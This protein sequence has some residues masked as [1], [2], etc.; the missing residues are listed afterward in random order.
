MLS[1]LLPYKR[2]DLALEAARRVG[3]PAVVAGDGPDRQAG[4]RRSPDPTRSS[5]AASTTTRSPACIAGASAFFLGGEEDF[6]ITPLEANAAGRPVVAYGG[7][8]ALETVRDGD[9][10]VLFG[11][12][13]PEEAAAG[14]ERALGTTW[15]PD[16]LATHA[17][18]YSAGT[19]LDRLER[20]VDE[21]L[22]AAGGMSAPEASIVIVTRNA[23]A[24]CVKL[25]RSLPR[26][27]DV[28]YEVVVVDNRSRLPTR[29]LLIGLALTGRIN[30]LC[31]MDRN[32]LF[33]EGNN[34]G[35]AAASRAAPH[36]LLLNS[37]VEVRDPPGSGGCSTP[38]AAARRRSASSRRGRCRAP[39]ATASSS[40]A[41]STSRAASTR[42]TSGGGASRSCRRGCC[43]P[44][45]PSRAV[46]EHDELLVHFGG[47]SGRGHKPA[48]G[49]DV[50][51]EEIQG[52]FDGRRW[53]PSS[54]S[55]SSRPSARAQRGAQRRRGARRSPVRSR[56]RPRPAPRRAARCAP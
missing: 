34:V 36:V 47:K 15:S 31:L 22:R 2:V 13:A 6:G 20:V 32:T 54:G 43:G 28:D 5:S 12:Q 19:F 51:P 1:R 46:R 7:G 38:I 39:T 8:G 17:E 26:T 35:V 3:I 55:S 30:R 42:R 9:T 25:F 27:R 14:L 52:W 24:Y 33:A 49:M 56:R 23:F 40:T 10:G 11:R 48:T 37:D 45:I 21:E 4:S 16:R 41:T 44:A 29:L 53:I 18:G 50:E